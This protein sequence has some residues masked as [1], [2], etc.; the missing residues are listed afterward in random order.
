[1]QKQKNVNRNKR[2]RLFLQFYYK[3]VQVYKKFK[4][5]TGKF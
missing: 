4:I 1:M 5:N 3:L 2:K